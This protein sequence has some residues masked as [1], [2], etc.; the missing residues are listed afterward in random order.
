M[1]PDEFVGLDVTDAMLDTNWDADSH[2]L[3]QSIVRASKII[4]DLLSEIEMNDLQCS[5]EEPNTDMDIAGGRKVSATF[6]DHTEEQRT[7]F[8]HPTE[9]ECTARRALKELVKAIEVNREKLRAMKKRLDAKSEGQV[10]IELDEQ[11]PIF[12]QDVD[13][14]MSESI[15]NFMTGGALEAELTDV[16]IVPH[17]HDLGIVDI[18]TFP[19]QRPLTDDELLTMNYGAPVLEPETMRTLREHLREQLSYFGPEMECI[20]CPMVIG[21]GGIMQL[22]VEIYGQRKSA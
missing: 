20:I 4:R 10:T 18:Q 22:Y 11:L 5:Y 16:T 6:V 3:V 7:L 19:Y 1:T 2:D 21:N 14:V 12:G 13:V 15:L 8:V 17:D 9:Q